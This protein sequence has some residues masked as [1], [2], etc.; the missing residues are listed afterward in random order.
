MRCKLATSVAPL[1]SNQASDAY[2]KA[3]PRMPL[4]HVCRAG[5][6]NIAKNRIT[7]HSGIAD[8]HCVLATSVFR[9][10][11]VMLYIIYDMYHTEKYVI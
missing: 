9:I 5:K 3:Y 11:L 7:Q 10:I 8:A 1:P 4:V 6:K 2:Q